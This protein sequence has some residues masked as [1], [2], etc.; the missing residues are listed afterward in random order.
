[1]SLEQSPAIRMKLKAD[2]M[3]GALAAE[4]KNQVQL[5]WGFPARKM[6]VPQVM[7]GL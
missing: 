4:V 3:F 1:M 7:V 6:G 5:T 2:V